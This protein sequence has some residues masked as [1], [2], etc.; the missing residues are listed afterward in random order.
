MKTFF[1]RLGLGFVFILVLPFWLVA[2]VLFA[3]FSIFVYLFTLISAV[4]A[5]F[6]G[7]SILAPSELDIAASTKLAEQ[8]HMASLPDAQLVAPA[9]QPTIIVNVTQGPQP[10]PQPQQNY[11][12]QDGVIYRAVTT[13]EAQSVPSETAV[14]EDSE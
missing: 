10:Q 6:K 11:I 2:F 5:Y 9:Q 3:V 4:P 7:E 8:K 14:K 1:K 13:T 12:E